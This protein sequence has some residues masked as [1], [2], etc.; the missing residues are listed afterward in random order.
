MKLYYLIE[1]A[2]IM[3]T[4]IAVLVIKSG[5]A[6]RMPAKFATLFGLLIICTY[7][8]GWIVFLP[9]GM[10]DTYLKSWAMPLSGIGFGFLVYALISYIQAHLNSNSNK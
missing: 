7:V 1:G 10:G 8:A 2:V 4:T 9:F 5:H 3:L 6:G